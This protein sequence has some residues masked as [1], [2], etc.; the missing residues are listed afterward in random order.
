MKK[1]KVFTHCTHAV[2]EEAVNKFLAEHP[3][4]VEDI[5]FR[6]SDDGKYSVIYSVMIV[7]DTEYAKIDARV[8]ERHVREMNEAGESD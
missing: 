2:L 3:V 7:Y 1:I 8:Y 4:S 6:M 5:Q